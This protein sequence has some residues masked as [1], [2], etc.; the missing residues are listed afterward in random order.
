[1]TFLLR[2]FMWQGLYNN[3]LELNTVDESMIERR[4]CSDSRCRTWMLR[5][6]DESLITFYFD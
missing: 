2:K 6:T 3:S 5:A 1:M 4:G